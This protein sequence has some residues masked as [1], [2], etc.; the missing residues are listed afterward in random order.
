M[1]KKISRLFAWGFEGTTVSRPIRSLLK[2]RPPA[3]VILFK[4]NLE[5]LRQLRSL[6][7][8]LQAASVSPLLIGID[9]EGG[10]VTRLPAPWTPLPP[11]A[12]LGKLKDPQIIFDAGRYLGRTLRSLGINTDFA[13]VL[14]VDSNPKNPIIGDRAFSKDPQA[15]ARDAVAFF[16]GLQKEGII[17]CGKHF[18]GHGDTSTDSHLTLPVV[19]KGERQLEKIELFPF[20]KAIQA[21]IPMIMT[22]HVVYPAWDQTRPATL[23]PFI[24]QELLRKRIGFKGVIVSDDLNMKGIADHY[25]LS[26]AVLLGLEAGIDL[27][28]ICRGGEKGEEILQKVSKEIEKS[29]ALLKRIEGSLRRTSHLNM[30]C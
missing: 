19:T 16:Q 7:A 9:E 1:T 29:P 2:E 18:P 27:F 4:R 12:L 11:A 17:A 21:G 26:E 6:T 30:R 14:D 23:S 28:L 13:P 5:G 22:A 3:G 25:E 24:L 10:R 8:D 20:R 15:A